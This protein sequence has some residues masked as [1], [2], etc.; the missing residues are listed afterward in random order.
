MPKV[1]LVDDERNL[2]STLARALK[3]EGYATLEAEDGEQALQRLA[4]EP[5]DAVLLDLQMP[6]RDGFSVLEAIRE[7]GIAVPV[8]VLTAHGTIEKAVRAVQLG[9]ADFVEKPPSTERLLVSLENALR[10]RYLEADNRR[11]AAEAGLGDDI[12]GTSAPMRQLGETIGKVA[13]TEAAVLLLGEN[14][15]GKELVARALH[16]GSPRR[17]RPL[18]TVNCAAIPDTLFESELFG[19]ARGAF[20]GATEARRGKF[21]EADGGTLFLD[22]VGEI[23]LGL[24]PKLLRALESGEVER[25]GGRGP[26]RVD[27]RIVAATNRD[28]ESE[29]AAGRFRQDLY[30]RLLVVPVR[31]PPLRERREDVPLLAAH[32]LAEACRKNRIRAKVLS[33]PAL[34]RLRSHSWPGNVRELRNAMERVAILVAEP[35]IEPRHLDF[36]QTGAAAAPPSSPAPGKEDLASYLERV[37]REAI[38]RVCERHHWRMTKA[39]AELGLE[40]SHLYKK[41]KALGIERPAED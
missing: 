7:R 18:V 25:V 1:L 40:R 33:E 38:L 36:L 4:D 31:V 6:G 15:S 24:Q 22:E 28:L 9:A 32:F 13:P 19:H 12:L 30:F 10:R 39:A 11:L 23:P 17:G 26:E 21:Q 37:E 34:G 14:G 35:L 20:T 5:V 2:R 8:V 16:A 3:L 41:L 27:A 29:V